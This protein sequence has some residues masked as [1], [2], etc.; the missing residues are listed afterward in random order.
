PRCVGVPATAGSE[1]DP[2]EEI[3][4]IVARCVTTGAIVC[5]RRPVELAVQDVLRT[6][7]R[8]QPRI[9]VDFSDSA[10]AARRPRDAAGDGARRKERGVAAPRRREIARGERE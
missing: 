6:E 2:E 4:R 1:R 10:A 3:E 5:A 9:E 8:V 7:P